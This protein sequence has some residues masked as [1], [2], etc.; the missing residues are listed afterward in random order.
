M[1]QPIN[2]CC[3]SHQV[4][5]NLLPFG[6]RQIAGDHNAVSL[7][8]VGTESEENFHISPVLLHVADAI[9]DQCFVLSVLLENAYQFQVPFRDQQFVHQYVAR[10]KA[11]LSSATPSLLAS[12]HVKVRKFMILASSAWGCRTVW[13]GSALSKF[14]FQGLTLLF[15]F[16][17]FPSRADPSYALSYAF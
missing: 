17:F 9:N 15:P 11:D 16:L 10:Y 2:R 12:R 3:C 4:F 6:E 8:A 7:I 1:D 14:H 5:K 13:L